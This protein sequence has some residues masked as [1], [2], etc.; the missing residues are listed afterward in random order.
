MTQLWRGEPFSHQGKHYQI[1]T[2][3]LNAN[4]LPLVQQPRI[5]IWVVG[6]W[7]RP[8]S[9]RRVLRCDG[10]I[11]IVIPKGKKGRGA[12]PDDIQEIQTWLEEKPRLGSGH[13]D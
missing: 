7:P 3:S 12:T 4:M 6:A 10:I 5:P 8:K 2:T 13:C 11:P 9:M 1:D